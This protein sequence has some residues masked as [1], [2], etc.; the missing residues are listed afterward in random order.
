MSG[1]FF[2]F[3]SLLLSSARLGFGRKRSIIERFYCSICK[4][5]SKEQDNQGYSLM[6]WLEKGLGS[7]N[8]TKN[9]DIQSND[10]QG[11][12]TKKSSTG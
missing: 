4:R 1:L 2:I 8:T 10:K 12:R 3:V 6:A 7:G 5:A 11:R 9:N